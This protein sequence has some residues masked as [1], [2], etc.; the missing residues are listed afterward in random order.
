MAA[1]ANSILASI[2]DGTLGAV[3]DSILA[4]V[5]DVIQV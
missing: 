2:T 1:V 3:A 5:T 4:S